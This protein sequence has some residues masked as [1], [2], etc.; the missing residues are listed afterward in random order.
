MGSKGRKNRRRGSRD[1]GRARTRPVKGMKGGA[2][3]K[4]ALYRERHMVEVL[5]ILKEWSPP[6]RNVH[7][8]SQKT[9]PDGTTEV[10]CL[11][12]VAP[13]DSKL[14]GGG[15]WRWVKSVALL[16]APLLPVICSH[17]LNG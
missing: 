10:K 17:L 1:V 15:I 13:K 16:L 4:D 7:Y 2:P 14:A 3:G 8:F 12:V 6:D 9:H 11:D 5:R